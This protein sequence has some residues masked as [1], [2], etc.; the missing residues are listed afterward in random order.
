MGVMFVIQRKTS[1]EQKLYALSFM[2]YK[3]GGYHEGTLEQ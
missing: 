3:E 2:L 1:E